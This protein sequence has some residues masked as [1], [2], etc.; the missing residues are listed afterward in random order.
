M[1]GIFRLFGVGRP[2]TGEKEP[3]PKP[4]TARVDPEAARRSGMRYCECRQCYVEGSASCAMCR[5]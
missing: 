3:D 1:F 5:I 4:P 2:V